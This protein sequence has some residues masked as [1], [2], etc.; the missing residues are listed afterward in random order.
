MAKKIYVGNL[1]LS[2]TE[3]EVRELF[4]RFGAVEWVHLVTATD[5]GRSRGIGFV[6]MAS[7]AGKA[8]RRLDHSRV[9]DRLVSVKR[10]LP[11]GSSRVARPRVPK[12][13]RNYRLDRGRAAVSVA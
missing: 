4:S 8:I 6:A 11:P 13:A 9:G 10:A 5:T 12:R 3:D 1:P 2:T 7:G